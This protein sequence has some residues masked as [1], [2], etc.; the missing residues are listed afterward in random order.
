[1]VYVD[2]ID[3]IKPNKNFTYAAVNNET[4]FKLLEGGDVVDFVI[5]FR[6]WKYLTNYTRFSK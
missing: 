4:N 3:E 5:D 2:N 1:V 6:D